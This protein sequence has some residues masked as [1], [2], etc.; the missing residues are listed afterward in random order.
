MFRYDKWLGASLGWMFGGPIGGVVGYL[1]GDFMEQGNRSEAKQLTDGISDFEVNLIVLA[2]HLIKIDGKVSL[3][4]IQ[5]AENFLNEVFNKKFASKRSRLLAHCLQKEYDL[6]IAC[7]Q[8]RMYAKLI[9]RQQIVHFLFD[10]A[11]ADGELNERENYFIFKVAGYL[12]VNDVQFRRIKKEHFEVEVDETY[13]AILGVKNNAGIREI[14]SAYRKLVL[15]YHPDRNKD[16]TES[17]RKKLAQK[18]QQV[19][20]AYEKVKTT[21]K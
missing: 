20:N 12:T 4:E 11:E 8:I 13:Y 2:T 10:L 3:A 19:Q 15:K 7:G 14:R 21:R 1:A 17:E 5:F 16:A 6:D 9:T 18:F